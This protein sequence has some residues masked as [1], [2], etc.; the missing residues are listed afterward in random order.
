MPHNGKT[1]VT[2]SSNCQI[3]R[4]TRPADQIGTRHNLI[5]TKHDEHIAPIKISEL[6]VALMNRLWIPY[7]STIVGM[8]DVGLSHSNVDELSK[9]LVLQLLPDEP[10]DIQTMLHSLEKR[11]RLQVDQYPEV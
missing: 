5:P 7:S 4:L 2:Y 10:E 8:L 1:Q 6:T 9:W 3:I 11:F